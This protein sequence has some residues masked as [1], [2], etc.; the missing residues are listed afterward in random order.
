MLASVNPAPRPRVVASQNKRQAGRKIR[1]AGDS[2]DPAPFARR[3]EFSHRSVRNR[4]KDLGLSANSRS[5]LEPTRQQGE[6]HVRV[7]KSL[8]REIGFHRLAATQGLSQ[9]AQLRHLRC[10]LGGSQPQLLHQQSQVDSE[11]ARSLNRTA[12]SRTRHAL[13]GARKF[14]G[15]PS[16]LLPTSSD[17]HRPRESSPPGEA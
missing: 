8:N 12:R 3:R 6:F 1:A 14:S 5:R 10:S 4:Y 11:L 16:R 15:V 2:G 17:T 7:R 9:A 13:F